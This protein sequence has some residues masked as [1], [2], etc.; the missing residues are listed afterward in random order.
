MH[1]YEPGSVP[2][3]QSHDHPQAD[4]S[5]ASAQTQTTHG[6]SSISR[7]TVKMHNWPLNLLILIFRP[8]IIQLARVCLAGWMRRKLSIALSR[9]TSAEEESVYGAR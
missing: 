5:W 7:L 8:L 1:S 2:L 3:A 6:F 9:F 4:P